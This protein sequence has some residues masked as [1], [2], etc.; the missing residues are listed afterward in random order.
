[1]EKVWHHVFS[2][3]LR[4]VDSQDQPLLLTEPPLNPHHNREIMTTMAFETF[5]TPAM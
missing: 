1:M 4:G 3:E 5:Q 2:H